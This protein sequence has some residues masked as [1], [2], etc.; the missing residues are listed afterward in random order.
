MDAIMLGECLWTQGDGAWSVLS[1][2]GV[3]HS[4]TPR[5]ALTYLSTSPL[6]SPFESRGWLP[7]ENTGH[8]LG[9][10]EHSLLEKPCVLELVTRSLEPPLPDPIARSGA[11]KETPEGGSLKSGD[12]HSFPKI[13]VGM[14]S[15]LDV[16]GKRE[17]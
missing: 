1:G 12:P 17:Q 9:N 6:C 3:L 4:P 7:G 5:I 16:P 14:L 2:M 13:S 15:G 8:S 10:K 11:E